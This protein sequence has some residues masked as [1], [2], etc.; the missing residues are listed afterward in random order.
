MS[1][2]CDVCRRILPSYGA[3]V[4]GTRSG[5]Q[6]SYDIRGKVIGSPVSRY[7]ILYKHLVT[8]GWMRGSLVF[9]WYYETQISM[10]CCLQHATDTN[11]HQHRLPGTS[12]RSPLLGSPLPNPPLCHPHE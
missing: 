7:Y 6:L 3:I 10:P 5:L 12:L 9:T 4:A 2:S 1:Q 8:L 11:F